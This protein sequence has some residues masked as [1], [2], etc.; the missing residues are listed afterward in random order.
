MLRPLGS[1][2][3]VK[4]IPPEVVAQEFHS[5]RIY[6]EAAEGIVVA[7]G[8]GSLQEAKEDEKDSAKMSC[9]FV[10]PDVE[11]GDRVLIGAHN[12]VFFKDKGEEFIV[13]QEDEILGVL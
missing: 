2:V 9:I 4:L 12:G 1:R 11:L 6:T 7:I 8:K 10:P 5:I 13:L 3:V